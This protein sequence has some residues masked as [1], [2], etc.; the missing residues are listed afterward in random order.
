MLHSRE[1]TLL[2]EM[3]QV[4]FPAHVGQLTTICNTSFREF[5]LLFCVLQT[6]GSHTYTYMNIKPERKKEKNKDD[7]QTNTKTWE[8]NMASKVFAL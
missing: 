4:Q 8:D 6:C 7:I 1:H 5:S 2:L 3:A